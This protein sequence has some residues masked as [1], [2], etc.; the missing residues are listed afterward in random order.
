MKVLGGTTQ[1]YVT[2][3]NPSGAVQDTMLFQSVFE[4][5]L[6]EPVNYATGLIIF[7]QQSNAKM[8]RLQIN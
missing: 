6:E 7:G 2:M 8:H 5:V 4:L 1:N 3:Q